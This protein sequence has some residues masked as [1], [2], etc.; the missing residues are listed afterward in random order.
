M[1]ASGRCWTSGQEQRPVWLGA[2]TYDRSVGVSHYTG[3]I[4]HHIGADID[5]ERKLLAADLE[6][7]GMVDAKYQVTGIGPTMT[8]R[9]GGGDPYYTDGEVWILRLVEACQKRTGPRRRHPEPAGDRDQGPDLARDR[10]MRWGNRQALA[11]L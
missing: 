8:G 7:A 1:C 5:A 4:T 11:G 3:A 10:R 6:A 2:A 9:N